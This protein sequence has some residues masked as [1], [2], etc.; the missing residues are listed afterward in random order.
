MLKSTQKEF[1]PLEWYDGKIVRYGNIDSSHPSHFLYAV[2]DCLQDFRVLDAKGKRVYIENKRLEIAKNLDL[3]VLKRMLPIRILLE[4]YVATFKQVLQSQ[5]QVL[6]KIIDRPNVFFK[7]LDEEVIHESHLEPFVTSAFQQCLDE[8]EKTEKQQIKADKKE[9]CATLFQKFHEE[10]WKLTLSSIL[11]DYRKRCADPH[12]AIDHVMMIVLLYALP[13]NV[14]FIDRD[15]QNI[16]TIDADY[17]IYSMD[18]KTAQN[19]FLLFSYPSSFESIGVVESPA[20]TN[21]KQVKVRRLFPFQHAFVQ[22]AI[23]QS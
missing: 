8:I 16:V 2:F 9:K 13:M 21:P 7:Q 5:H 4:K 6:S 1:F 18:R 23:K 12:I 3:V 22:S 10:I 17:Y 20:D 19:I 15:L 11:E 14:F